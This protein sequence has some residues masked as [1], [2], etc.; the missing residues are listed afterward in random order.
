MISF[1]HKD[2]VKVAIKEI[3]QTRTANM[4]R[5]VSLVPC[6]YIMILDDVYHVDSAGV[7]LSV[8]SVDFSG[9]V[10]HDGHPRLR[11]KDQ[12]WDGGSQMVVITL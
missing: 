2:T 9:Q 3:F 1:D 11:I 7:T 10:S 8:L 5:E 4:V 6:N 12:E